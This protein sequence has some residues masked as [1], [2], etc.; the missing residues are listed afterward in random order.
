MP[1]IKVDNTKDHANIDPIRA[2]RLPDKEQQELS[3]EKTETIAE[4][5]KRVE[6]EKEK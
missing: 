2:A 6:A 4:A 1:T 3:E 5:I